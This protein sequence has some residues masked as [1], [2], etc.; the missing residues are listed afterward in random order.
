M[1]MVVLVCESV[2]RLKTEAVSSPMDY[3]IDTALYSTE[4]SGLEF[5]WNVL[6]SLV[7]SERFRDLSGFNPVTWITIILYI[8]KAFR[9]Q[10]IVVHKEAFYES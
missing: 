7:F 1:Q 4:L 6:E 2:R 10:V 5:F 3:Q 8:P 9:T